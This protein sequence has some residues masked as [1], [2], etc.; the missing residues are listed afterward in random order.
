[1]EDMEQNPLFYINAFNRGQIMQENDIL[2]FLKQLNL[3]P[4]E[5]YTMPCSNKAIIK[6]VLRNLITAYE[7]IGNPQKERKLKYY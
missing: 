5:E 2:S 4:N 1:M 7:N 3:P 6:R